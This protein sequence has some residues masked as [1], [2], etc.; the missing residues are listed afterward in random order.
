MDIAHRDASLPRFVAVRSIAASVVALGLLAAIPRPALADGLLKED[1]AKA[2]VLLLSL[3]QA[4]AQK[5]DSAPTKPAAKPVPVAAADKTS[6]AA[7]AASDS[8]F[9]NSGGSTPPADQ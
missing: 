3:S 1:T 9:A 5:S 2:M 8:P 4:L 7:V 6:G